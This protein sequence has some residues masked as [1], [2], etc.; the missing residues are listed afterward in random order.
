MSG[1]AFDNHARSIVIVPHRYCS[2][3]RQARFSS[4]AQI[5]AQQELLPWVNPRS[6]A[7]LTITAAATY[8]CLGAPPVARCLLHPEYPLGFSASDQRP[9]QVTTNNERSRFAAIVPQVVDGTVCASHSGLRC[10]CAGHSHY[11]ARA[12]QSLWGI[13]ELRFCLGRRILR[14]RWIGTPQR[15]ADIISTPLRRSDPTY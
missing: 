1:R 14:V 6:R 3:A 2:E 10:Q 13:R 5:F 4:G 7:L 15:S 12:G 11:A 8:G 9:A